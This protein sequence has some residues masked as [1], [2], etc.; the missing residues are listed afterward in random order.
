M[1]ILLLMML[2][3]QSVFAS[4]TTKAT[5]DGSQT[6]ITIT[7]TDDGLDG[8][9]PIE[10]VLACNQ[11][12]GVPDAI[13]FY[14]D[15]AYYTDAQPQLT[16]PQGWPFTC[17]GRGVFQGVN[18]YYGNP[19]TVNIPGNVIDKTLCYGSR[20]HAGRAG[21]FTGQ[22]C[23]PVS[24]AV[25]C[26]S[27]AS[28]VTLAHGDVAVAAVNG[29]TS[30]TTANVTCSGNAT[31][32]VWAIRSSAE[33]TSIVPV[34]VDNSI[35][36]QLTVNGVNGHTGVTI[37]VTANQSTSVTVGSTLAAGSPTIGALQ[38]SAVLV[39]DVLGTQAL[40]PIGVTGNVVVPAAPRAVLNMVPFA[41]SRSNLAVSWGWS[42]SST[43]Y[44]NGTV[45]ADYSVGLFIRNDKQGAWAKFETD[46]KPSAAASW[47][48]RIKRFHETYPIGA[49]EQEAS[50]KFE[51]G[52]WCVRLAAASTPETGGQ[53]LPAPGSAESCVD[54]P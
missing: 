41:G 25:T 20:S 6:H 26:S 15:S 23:V 16:F 28:A 9:R 5:F 50:R 1:V 32:N 33:P 22:R 2:A 19:F 49:I 8:G 42:T 31:L 38:G 40:V 46:A 29:N 43:D 13:K 45:P 18:K 12:G 14:F 37:P 27:T 52:T 3:S 21:Q 24:P 47:A 30:S 51:S 35:T 7:W 48:D 11:V 10:H 53:F 39:L 4:T 17:D 36:S 44:G 54:V 34:R